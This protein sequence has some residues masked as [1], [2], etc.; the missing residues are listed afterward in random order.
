[1]TNT[2]KCITAAVLTMLAGGLTAATNAKG[3]NMKNP[4]TM[5]IGGSLN[6]KLV[7]EYMPDLKENTDSGV[8][9]IKI[10][11]TKGSEYTVWISGGSTPDLGFSVDPDYFEDEDAPM[12]FFDYA[13]RDDGN[14]QIAYMYADSWSS[15]D[16]QHGTY[17]IWIMG[18]IGQS[19]TVRV[20]SGIRS[21][22]QEG[23][24]DNPRRLTMT[25]TRQI[26]AR[27]QLG[28]GDFYYVMYLEAGRK[29]RIWVAG[30]TAQTF[31]STLQ[32]GDL[33][34]EGDTFYKQPYFSSIFAWGA[35]LQGAL[36][37]VQK[38]VA[39]GAQEQGTAH[40]GH[41][42]RGGGDAWPREFR[43]HRQL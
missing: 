5:S 14:V 7:N 36:P 26:D 10:N 18:E 35:E 32:V 42:L 31:I 19:T 15:D 8:C 34:P 1:M 2:I 20:A 22:S 17:Y 23:E 6:V 21:F 12:A 30:E 38:A 9:Y 29:Y 37:G 40:R 11:L 16:P 43:R 28:D 24:E 27:T 39:G 33:S 3:S 25:E 4:L 41:G 13:F